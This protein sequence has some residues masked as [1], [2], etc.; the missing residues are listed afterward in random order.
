MLDSL[1]AGQLEREAAGQ[2]LRPESRHEVSQTP[3]YIG[4]TVVVCRR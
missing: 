3:A 1:D 2:G 4:S